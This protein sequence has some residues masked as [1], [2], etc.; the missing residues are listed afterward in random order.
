M[1]RISVLSIVLLTVAPCAVKGFQSD[2]VP[3]RYRTR[4]SPYAFSYDS[5]GLVP[6][7]VYYSPYAYMSGR[8]GLVPYWVNYSPYA[9]SYKHSGLISDYGYCPFYIYRG[10]GVCA[11][12]C[13]HCGFVDQSKCHCS[14]TED[15][16]SCNL[17]DSVENNCQSAVSNRNERARQLRKSRAKIRSMRQ[18]DGKDIICDY[19]KSNNMADFEICRVLRI[20]DKTVCADFLLR[21]K[22]IVITYWNPDEIESLAQ[23]PRYKR[24][25]Y[26]RYR[27][28]WEEFCQ[29][30][31]ETGAKVYL[32]GSSD[33]QEI[34]AQL[35][36]CEELSEG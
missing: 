18:S 15:C 27:Q 8:T 20:D 6:G 35:E 31:R 7:T 29:K 25:F 24:N 14:R 12:C 17:P 26:E 30:C 34:W 10:S 2:R 28:Q 19:L 4:Y 13:G 11:S 1:K 32:I 33:R 16:E 22:N 21:D 23:Q 36:L 9:F 5:C 3:L